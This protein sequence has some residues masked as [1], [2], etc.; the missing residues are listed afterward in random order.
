MI[1][2]ED[3]VFLANWDKIKQNAAP[4]FKYWYGLL[5]F[6]TL[7]D[8]RLLNAASGGTCQGPHCAVPILDRTVAGSASFENIWEMNNANN[9][10]EPYTVNNDHRRCY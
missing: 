8:M 10:N 2:F 6:K 9:K 4:L 7:W 5:H 1:Q 3:A